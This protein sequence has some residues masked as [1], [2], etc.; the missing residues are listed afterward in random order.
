M[1]RG[2]CI[3]PQ[4]ACCD[5]E[6]CMPT[7]FTQDDSKQIDIHG[8]QTTIAI[9][10]TNPKLPREHDSKQTHIDQLQTILLK[11]NNIIINHQHKK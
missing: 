11:K 10:E 3:R 2:T 6:S 1:E 9:V 7:N 4:I 8:L 5:I